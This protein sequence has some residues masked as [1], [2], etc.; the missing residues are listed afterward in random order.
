MFS[1]KVRRAAALLLAL[2]VG[3]FSAG[4]GD[5]PR[6][7]A[8][9]QF[10]Q[11][12]KNDDAEAQYN[13][14]A[15]YEFGGGAPKDV[16]LAKKWYEKAA[17]QGHKKAVARLRVLNP[18]KAP[19]EEEVKEIRGS[20]LKYDADAE[21]LFKWAECC[22]FGFHTERDPWRALR[23][24]SR[25]AEKGH[26]EAGTRAQMLGEALS[27]SEA[28][29]KKIRAD[30]R[31]K[32]AEAQYKLAQCHEFGFHVRRDIGSARVWYRRAADQGHPK[33]MEVLGRKPKPKPKPRKPLKKRKK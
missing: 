30:A 28:E 32:N 1:S 13:L 21:A 33:A 18:P 3:A 19:T 17:A 4:C 9:K 7:D 15:S 31:N 5:K 25:A 29:V 20:A 2:A 14:G 10:L 26:A 22:E 12:A 11:A 24:Y 8:E 27:P 16:A 6:N 23:Y